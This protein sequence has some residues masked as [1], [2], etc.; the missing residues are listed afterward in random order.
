VWCATSRA[1]L[2]PATCAH[3]SADHHGCLGAVTAALPGV[4]KTDTERVRA[5]FAAA[6]REHGMPEAIRTDNGAPFS[7]SAVG[8]LSRLAVWW[9]RLGIEHER[10]RPDHPKQT[11]A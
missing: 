6:F 9:T 8:G 5:I 7:S 11:D 4:E 10:S 2:R 3:R 1:G